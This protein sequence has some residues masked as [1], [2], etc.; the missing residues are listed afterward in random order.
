M[1]ADRECK[2][3]VG[4][5]PRESACSRGDGDGSAG[6]VR[7][8]TRLGR[9]SGWCREWIAEWRLLRD[10]DLGWPAWLCTRV[11]TELPTSLWQ[12][13]VCLVRISV[14]GGLTSAQALAGRCECVD[15]RDRVPGRHPI[16]GCRQP[17]LQR[18]RVS[19]RFVGGLSGCDRLIWPHRDGLI[20]P[21]L[22]LAGAVMTV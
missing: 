4:L 11:P 20:W 5:Q 17:W 7:H 16:P 21:H 2:S 22:R 3:C 1:R 9:G 13:P 19:E 15:R 18:H 12:H 8:E 10:L 14:R 6:A